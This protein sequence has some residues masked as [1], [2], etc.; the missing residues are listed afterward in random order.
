[1]RAMGRTARACAVFDWAT[2]TDD[3]ADYSQEDGQVLTVAKT[4]MA[5][6]PS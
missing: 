2:A 1:M 3:L 4:A 6:A 5:S